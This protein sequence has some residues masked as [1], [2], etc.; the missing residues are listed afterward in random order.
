MRRSIVLAVFTGLLLVPPPSVCAFGD[1]NSK[2]L[3]LVKSGGEAF[4]KK[5]YRRAYKDFKRASAE[6]RNESTDAALGWARTSFHLAL[7]SEARQASL[8]VLEITADS[9]I[10]EE[11][12]RIHAWNVLGLALYQQ[13]VDDE[14]ERV[15][16]PHVDDGESDQAVLAEAEDAFRAVIRLT[17]ASV[18]QAFYNLAEVL[19]RLGRNEE[20]LETLMQYFSLMGDEDASATAKGLKCYLHYQLGNRS[21]A[22]HGSETIVPPRKV[23]SSAPSLPALAQQNG[24]DGTVI[25]EAIIDTSGSVRC[26]RVLR[27]LPLGLTEAA[28]AAV[29]NWRFEP[30]S[31]A[32]TGEPV[33]T[34]YRLKI[35]FKFQH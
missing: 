5:N 23:Y 34:Q 9:S 1:T 11:L 35:D 33:E 21:R 16:Q 26:L 19:T 22:S 24:V 31:L 17:S 18:A 8:H 2:V 7:F 10:A 20:A 12:S 29:H 30:A 4:S 13:Y 27:G 3:R 14:F 28:F 32:S 6:A 25:L 15:F